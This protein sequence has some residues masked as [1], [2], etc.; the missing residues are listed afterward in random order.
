M[1]LKFNWIKRYKI[2]GFPVPSEDR[3][4][5]LSTHR[6]VRSSVTSPSDPHEAGDNLDGTTPTGCD[7]AVKSPTNLPLSE[8]VVKRSL[9][10]DCEPIN[11][12]SFPSYTAKPRSRGVGKPNRLIR[13]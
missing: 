5:L 7:H 4:K 6:K 3:Y 12:Q 1:Q 10:V 9:L 13:Y 11:R 2:Q 8:R